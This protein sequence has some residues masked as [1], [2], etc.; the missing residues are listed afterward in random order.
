MVDILRKMPLQDIKTRVML[1]LSCGLLQIC[2]I[3]RESEYQ[4]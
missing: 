1:P 3:A 2:G 4:A